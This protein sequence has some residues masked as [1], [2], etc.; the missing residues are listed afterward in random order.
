MGRTL[1]QLVFGVGRR[2]HGVVRTL[3]VHLCPIPLV[4]PDTKATIGDLLVEIARTD[5][6]STARSC[7]IVAQNGILLLNELVLWLDRADLVR[8]A[9][10]V[11]LS[12][13]TQVV[14]QVRSF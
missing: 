11:K 1:K 12:V 2:N 14:E 5:T 9:S 7:V 4:H 6:Y 8:R 13:V 10:L 3:V